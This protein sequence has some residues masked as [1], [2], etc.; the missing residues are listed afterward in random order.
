MSDTPKRKGRPKGKPKKAITI[1]L[2]NELYEVLTSFETLV[3]ETV[4]GARVV[5]IHEAIFH[6]FFFTYQG[7]E[8]KPR[9]DLEILSYLAEYVETKELQEA[10]RWSFFHT[11][12]SAEQISLWLSAYKERLA[13]TQSARDE[14][15]AQLQAD[16]S[17]W[18]IDR[19]KRELEQIR[20]R[21]EALE[22][23]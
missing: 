12:P 9:N 10:E 7:Q 17:E 23:G 4:Q 18:D 21:L 3:Q 6:Y 22:R 1:R 16:Q 19:F 5:D 20:K 14:R 8:L 15:L 13:A 2:D 11:A